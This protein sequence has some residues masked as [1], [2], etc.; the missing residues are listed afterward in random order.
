MMWSKYKA[1]KTEIDGIIFDSKREANRYMYLRDSQKRGDIWNL[2]MQVKYV[3]IPAQYEHDRTGRMSGKIRG[4]LLEREC[5]Y[6]SDF[7][8][9]DEDGHHVEDVKG[10]KTPAYAIKRKLMLHVHG[11]RITEV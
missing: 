3:L 4:R 9:D 5:S 11:I 7:E 8:Y 10:V 1:K 2:Q 6:Y